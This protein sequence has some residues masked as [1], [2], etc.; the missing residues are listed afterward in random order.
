MHKGGNAVNYDLLRKQTN[1]GWNTWNTRNV[2][3]HAH[4]PEGFAINLCIKD[5]RSVHT[6]RE[7]LVGRHAQEEEI[8]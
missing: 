2:L 4:L 7:S 1:F 5:F 3:C 6:L 8:I